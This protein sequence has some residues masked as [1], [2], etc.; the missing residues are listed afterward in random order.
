M[1]MVGGPR[2][3]SIV[4]RCAALKR[5]WM[6]PL[7]PTRIVSTSRKVVAELVPDPINRRYEIRIHSWVSES[8]MEAAKAGTI[9]REGKYGEAYFNSPGGRSKFTRQ[10]FLLFEVIIE[11]P[12]G[13]T[14]NRLRLWEKHDFMPRP[15]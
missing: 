9:G 6:V 4:W 2:C 11:K 12:D 8:E 15:D 1:V 5:G 7:L 10:K 14:G 13:T 3:F